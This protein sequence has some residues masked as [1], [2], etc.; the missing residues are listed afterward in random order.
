[1]KVFITANGFIE[2]DSEG[3]IEYQNEKAA[4]I[5]LIYPFDNPVEYVV[6]QVRYEGASIKDLELGRALLCNVTA[7]TDK[8]AKSSNPVDL[9]WWRGGNATITDIKT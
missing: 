8:L 7:T 6:A 5:R 2:N 1:M 9:S 3:I 4:L